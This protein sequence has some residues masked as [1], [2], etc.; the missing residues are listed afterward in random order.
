MTDV[1]Q[2]ARALAPRP[3]WPALLRGLQTRCPACGT[4][5]LYG[6]YLKVADACPQ[7]SEALHH[8]RADD[9]PPYITM[10]IVGHV[11]I[12]SLLSVEMA[13]HPETWVHMVLWGPVTLLLSLWLLPRVKGALIGI[14]WAARMHGFG[15]GP[16][17]AEPEVWPPRGPV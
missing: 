10:L 12:G 14:Q 3:M 17:P 11:V 9:A 2:A 1:I 8:Q 7:C 6:R 5:A 16:D 4:G 15:G 13:Y